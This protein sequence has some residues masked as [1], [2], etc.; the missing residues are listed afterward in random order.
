MERREVIG[1]AGAL[2]AASAVQA[3]TPAATGGRTR[4]ELGQSTLQ[5]ITG[6]S[7][8][9]VVES[10]RDMAPDFAGWIL[11]FAYGDVMA[12]PGLDRRTRQFA[13]VAAL[14]A[15]GTARPQL[16][17]HLNGALN[18]GC[19]PAEIVEVMLQ[20]AVYAGFPSTINGL[21]VAREV[22]QE[23]GVSAVP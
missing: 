17:V 15:L 7:G 9:S 18:V 21:E 6:G 3:A 19:K 20:M 16:K 14:T 4:R 10:L 8:A 1:A 23:R 12:R 22:F 5:A 11:D 13:T 2:L